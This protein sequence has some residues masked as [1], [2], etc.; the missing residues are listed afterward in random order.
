MIN[1]SFAQ[2]RTSGAPGG[3]SSIGQRVVS[4]NNNVRIESGVS[5]G[6][7]AS[8]HDAFAGRP[9]VSSPSSIEQQGDQSLEETL[10]NMSEKDRWGLPGFFAAY[11]DPYT[12]RLMRG[13]DLST[14]GL[15]ME[16]SEPLHQRFLGPF[17]S[18]RAVPRP[19]ETEYTVPACYTVQNVVPLQQRINGFTEET[20]FYIF[21][22]MPRD[23]TQELVAEELMGRKWRFHLREKMWLT[24]DENAPAPVE[25]EPGVSES[26]TYLW[27]NPNVWRRERR[28]YLLRYDELDDHLQRSGAVNAAA[29][30]AGANGGAMAG[31]NAVP[32]LERMAAGMGRNF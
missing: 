7:Q 18:E 2:E 21:Y 28:Q 15:R 29:N 13:Q 14:L 27:W 22:T 19:L 5:D 31:F 4:R 3:L 17:A 20:L 1:G 12:N 11:Q 9:N 26:G 25:I 32:G 10:G 8:S 23:I 30:T 16:Q 24:R 6:E